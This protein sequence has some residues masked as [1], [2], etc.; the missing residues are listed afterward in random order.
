MRINKLQKALSSFL[1][2]ED[3]DK[4]ARVLQELLR[5]G[6]VSYEKVEE[7]IHE[8]AEDTI[9]LGYGWR[10]ILPT[11]SAKSG[12]WE[13][14]ILLPYPGETY[15]M[16]NVT[17]HLVENAGKTGQWDPEKA[18]LG[19][20][21]NIGEPDLDKMTVLVE[22]I[23]SEAKGR[24]ISGIQIKSICVELDLEARVDPLLSELK[25]CGIMSPKLSS[26][27]DASRA[28]S[29]IYELNPSLFVGESEQGNSD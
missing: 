9:I 5:T 26:L 13:D 4:L 11:R 18:I 22:R 15:Q 14:R 10:L 8:A 1:N 3:A 7:I 29:P 27:T 25:A 12:D 23:A 16:P 19:V 21:R 24:R 28:G 17:K 20:F 2:S 6:E